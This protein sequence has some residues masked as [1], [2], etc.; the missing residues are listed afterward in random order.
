MSQDFGQARPAAHHGAPHRAPVRFVVVIDGGGVT[1]ARLCLAD[2][3]PVAE[4]DAGSD[5]VMRLIS[6]VVPTQ[7]AGGAEWD[8][9][10]AGHSA[11]ERADAQVYALSL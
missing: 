1:V 8:R 6:G 9:A 2:R 11:D 10:L 3:E 5:D 4:F 7:G